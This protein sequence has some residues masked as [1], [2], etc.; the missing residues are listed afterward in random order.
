M[1]PE[2]RMEPCYWHLVGAG[3]NPTIHKIA[4]PALM[5]NY[6]APNVK[7]AKVKKA[8]SMEA[9]EYFLFHRKTREYE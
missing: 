2:G 4:L 9:G 1:S 3:K 7:S 8:C 6:P 5:E